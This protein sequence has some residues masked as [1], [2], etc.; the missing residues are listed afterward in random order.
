MGGDIDFQ[1]RSRLDSSYYEA[2][3]KLNKAGFVSGI[4]RSS[5]GFHIIKLTG[6][7]TWEEADKA[8]VKRNLF[9]KQRQTLFETFVSD[10]RKKASVKIEASLL[11]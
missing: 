8:Q 1:N 10:L 3:L 4:V 2:A 11:K 5:S 7:H 9:E 6:I